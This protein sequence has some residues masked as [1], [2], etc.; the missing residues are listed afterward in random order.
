MKIKWILVGGIITLSALALE[1]ACV[2]AFSGFDRT[3]ISAAIPLII[4][5]SVPVLSLIIYPFMWLELGAPGNARCP[6]CGASNKQQEVDR[7][8]DACRRGSK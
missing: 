2:A 4:V 6:I 1:I 5:F 7:C 3:E 8:R